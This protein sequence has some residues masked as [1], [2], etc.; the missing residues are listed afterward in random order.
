ME[1]I[2]IG[3]EAQRTKSSIPS[4]LRTVLFQVLGYNYECRKDAKMLDV[5][6]IMLRLIINVI[7]SVLQTVEAISLLITSA[8]MIE[9]S[10]LQLLFPLPLSL[11]RD[12]SLESLARKAL[13]LGSIT[14]AASALPLF[15]SKKMAHIECI[16]MLHKALQRI[17]RHETRLSSTVTV[18]R[19]L[20]MFG[21]KITNETKGDDDSTNSCSTNCDMDTP[22]DAA[23]CSGLS[24]NGFQQ[25][26]DDLYDNVL[27]RI[28]ETPSSS[29]I[30]T[31][32]NIIRCG[33]VRKQKDLVEECVED[34]INIAASTFIETP[35]SDEM[36]QESEDGFD[37]LSDSPY[38]TNSNCSVVEVIV[39][40]LLSEVTLNLDQR[41]GWERISM[42]SQS[43]IGTSAEDLVK[44]NADITSSVMLIADGDYGHRSL[45]NKYINKDGG[46][47]A[48]A[49]LEMCPMV[50]KLLTD[51]KHF[52]R[53]CSS[54][55][56]AHHSDAI[57]EMI[58]V[59][60][61]AEKSIRDK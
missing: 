40:F 37:S 33:F 5:T 11:N 4:L 16:N 45:D 27:D 54:E 36:D 8:R 12:I 59:L 47:L 24:K 9:T 30:S 35:I 56:E 34:V 32:Q 26:G 38:I 42:I 46:T 52:V 21:L 10:V 14:V 19:Q 60:A 2:K 3:I 20:F 48:L 15:S 57:L 61:T 50:C 39:N 53:H 25:D 22:E 13:E 31:M 29:I 1:Q 43:F 18:A 51:Y 55:F 7:V 23:D 44:P 58:V 49:G 28:N 6:R 17:G 41:K